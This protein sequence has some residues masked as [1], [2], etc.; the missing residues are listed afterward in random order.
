MKKK[1]LN[2]NYVDLNLEWVLFL[3]FFHFS[4]RIASPAQP[5]LWHP[6]YVNFLISIISKFFY[7]YHRKKNESY[8]EF[9][10][11]MCT[12]L[13]I[14]SFFSTDNDLVC[15]PLSPE[16]MVSPTLVTPQLRTCFGAWFKNY[17]QNF[18]ETLGHSS[19]QYKVN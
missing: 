12:V 5:L 7:V 19:R 2:K 17:Y 1:K 14:F 16:C 10:F 6:P 9:Y 4:E 11:I 18:N 3:W 8:V 15:E 13:V